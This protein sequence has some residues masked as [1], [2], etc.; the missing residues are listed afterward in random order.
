MQKNNSKCI[1]CT[2]LCGFGPDLS[3][4]Y[5]LLDVCPHYMRVIGLLFLCCDP[6]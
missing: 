4:L 5:I 6:L 3:V 1:T 2:S